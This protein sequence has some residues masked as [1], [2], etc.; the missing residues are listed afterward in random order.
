M[1]F[2]AA[3]A[4][5]CVLSL[6]A[7]AG[8]SQSRP[9]DGAPST[10]YMRFQDAL[11][12]VAVH[13]QRVAG[14]WS[15]T[16]VTPRDVALAPNDALWVV[17]TPSRLLRVR[18]DGE[19][20]LRRAH[21]DADALREGVYPSTWA[22][23]PG[24]PWRAT[25][26]RVVARADAEA[27]VFEI[28][29]R[30]PVRVTCL[31]VVPA[32]DEL[33]WEELERNHADAPMSFTEADA[34][35]WNLPPPVAPLPWPYTTSSSVAESHYRRAEVLRRVLLARNGIGDT[36][37]HEGVT[38]LGDVGSVALADGTYVRVAAGDTVAFVAHGPSVVKLRS[39]LSRGGT[40]A[41]ARPAYVVDVERAGFLEQRFYHLTARD[42]D[43]S[44]VGL[45]RVR[46][47][48][49]L[50]PPGSH[51]YE[52]TA[53]ADILLRVDSYRKKAHVADAITHSED[54]GHHL[55]SAYR[56]ADA[57][58]Q[59][60]PRDDHARY[61]RAASLV[62]LG[63]YAASEADWRALAQAADH[64]L[65]A[66]VT[67]QQA[68]AEW[69]RRSYQEALTVAAAAGGLLRP[70]IMDELARTLFD[71]TRAVEADAFRATGQH[72]EAAEVY[73]SGGDA[74][75]GDLHTL[76]NR[77]H[78]LAWARDPA[79][80]GAY[81]E[82]IARYPYEAT[83][84]A[85]RWRFWWDETAWT[86]SRP[87]H[88]PSG[89]T[90]HMFDRLSASSGT[91]P[92][93]FRSMALG[94]PY[95]FQTANGSAEI[96]CSSHE[97]RPWMLSLH[98]PDGVVSAPILG[99][100]ERFSVAVRGAGSVVTATA[101]DDVGPVQLLVRDDAQR[102]EPVWV[103]RQY[104][105][106]AY[107]RAVEYDFDTPAP[108][109]LRVLVRS[110][111]SVEASLVVTLDHGE[112]VQMHSV[113]TQDAHE[114]AEFHIAVPAGRHHLSISDGAIEGRPLWVAVSIRDIQTRQTEGAPAPIMTVVEFTNAPGEGPSTGPGS[115]SAQPYSSAF[116]QARLD[117]LAGNPQSAADGLRDLA[118]CQ[119]LSPAEGAL[120]GRALRKAGEVDHAAAQ[121]HAV[122][123]ADPLNAEAQY[124]VA[125]MEFL[126]REPEAALER[127]TIFLRG[128]DATDL[129]R[130]QARYI[131]ANCSAALRRTAAARDAYALLRVEASGDSPTSVALRRQA[132]WELRRLDE[133][134][135]LDRDGARE[136]SAEKYAVAA[137]YNRA[138]SESPHVRWRA[139]V[140]DRFDI[141]DL[142]WGRIPPHRTNS[143]TSL[144]IAYESGE[145]AGAPYMRIGGSDD[146]TVNV[147]GP[148]L[149]RVELRAV[150]PAEADMHDREAATAVV[151][152]SGAKS[153]RWVIRPG[154]APAP[155]VSSASIVFP[156]YPDMRP[157]RQRVRYVEIPSGAHSVRLAAHPGVAAGRVYE[158]RPGAG[159]SFVTLDGYPARHAEAADY[160]RRYDALAYVTAYTP[161]DP[162]LAVRAAVALNRE[163]L[164]QMTRY[165]TASDSGATAYLM[166]TWQFHNGRRADALVTARVAVDGL[167]VDSERYADALLLL[168]RCQ[169][170]Q[171]AASTYRRYL[172]R[173][174]DDVR[175]RLE[176]ADIYMT[177]GDAATA[178]VE[179][180]GLYCQ[181]LNETERLS[182]THP[183]RRDV[184]EG[185]LAALRAT[186]WQWIYAVEDAAGSAVV[187]LTR[188]EEGEAPPWPGDG[189]LVVR[190]GVGLRYALALSED[191]SLRVETAAEGAMPGEVAW[192]L[193]E[194]S[195]GVIKGAGGDVA[196]SDIGVI[197]EG[198]HVLSLQTTE[199]A[200]P[201]Q[202]VRVLADRDLDADAP[203]DPPADGWWP[204]A[205][206]TR[207][208]AQV[209][210]SATPVVLQV[211]GP[212]R[213]RVTTRL[214][215][216]PHSFDK[217]IR[218][219]VTHD[220]VVVARKDITGPAT[221]DEYHAGHVF[222]PREGTPV[223][224]AVETTVAI[225]AAGVCRVEIA[226][227][228]QDSTP[229]VLVRL[230]ARVAA[231]RRPEHAAPTVIPLSWRR[232]LSTPQPR[233][234]GFVS[235]RERSWP[236]ASSLGT[237]ELQFGYGQRIQSGIDEEDYPQYGDITGRHR[238]RVGRSAYQRAG[239]SVRRGRGLASVLSAE[240]ELDVPLPRRVRLLARADIDMQSAGGELRHVTRASVETRRS[241][242]LTPTLLHVA[243]LRLSGRAFSLDN[244][245][246]RALPGLATDVFSLYGMQ[247]D[248]QLG[249]ESLLWFEPHLDLVL[250]GRTRL[251]TNRSLSPFDPDYAY[252]RV[253]ARKL[254]R[255]GVD[256][257]VYYQLRRWFEDD[258]RRESRF[259]SRAYLRLQSAAW[260]GAS[261]VTARAIAV[262]T[263][264]DREWLFLSG[265]T[266]ALP[267]GRG[268]S[269]YRPGAIDFRRFR[270]RRQ[271]A[272]AGL[273]SR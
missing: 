249:V 40:W 179:R 80:I 186:E 113:H 163:P 88:N 258:D 206:V 149:L 126:R 123:E 101:P 263:F 115:A 191:T 51:R 242:A 76:L 21:V 104:V 267:S 150:V 221:Y 246:R 13:V 226:P 128:Y 110:Q 26:R 57:Q 46:T 94:V 90:Q 252:T 231:P 129:R 216:R 178:A 272:I 137:D 176:L 11:P 140:R 81:D 210:D 124:E 100:R 168:A 235:G 29:A 240:E 83:P 47:G 89:R 159:A 259:E 86:R 155:P 134:Q 75:A 247:H 218:V 6:S 211:Q 230:H 236:A 248:R 34:R 127:A 109:Y 183:E 138:W 4:L 131:V 269:D 162:L 237:F 23:T 208:T 119:P 203:S 112:R 193:D 78:A 251:R 20:S 257:H 106:L 1:Q 271:S 102:E 154:E 18:T 187:E 222:G 130:L 223:S 213:L 232:P 10:S 195:S 67:A 170:G 214:L 74:G 136:M 147:A 184:D 254:W 173:R 165:A 98:T 192:V 185:R 201:R 91:A 66:G 189:W 153:E 164:E 145:T 58:A 273:R 62:L 9:A 238:I 105:P 180:T 135:G 177:L 243:R 166:A 260:R 229:R 199:I 202:W 250:Y 84:R 220:G 197:G 32:R 30:R 28:R 114:P 97:D 70:R 157:G 268:L 96:V 233:R 198:K 55:R 224:D 169:D 261:Y 209:A 207:V 142:D 69:R 95:T 24:D 158:L 93:A 161:V 99:R 25:G 111:S 118:T 244:D 82:I 79:T 125:V 36:F 3:M 39:R 122:L 172:T 92:G 108:T 64:L 12:E 77:A 212:T 190:S 151:E 148:T 54:I 27:T 68:R 42:A 205:P 85:R 87:T 60:D 270:T 241:H 132:T 116:E 37:V 41:D 19:V 7:F 160:V 65:R 245:E 120:L 33:A 239:L 215:G 141:F 53:D 5:A 16:A 45:G 167:P 139:S 194:M 22:T 63:D 50:A 227:R 264:E 253:G 56:L 204:V 117:M 48:A 133:R 72:A 121:L 14:Q 225:P 49:L 171:L 61:I 35:D 144:A 15:F 188:H 234:R 217:P 146:V 156:G 266:F 8:R 196:R 228:W 43:N 73:S 44:T 38:P 256:T 17:V 255:R 200:S 152:I 31:E 175:A 2:I 103:E 182:A 71:Y 219:T 52:L 59:A 181:A 265:L 107:W 174:G 262:Y 143:R